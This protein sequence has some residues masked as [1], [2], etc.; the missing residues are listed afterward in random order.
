MEPGQPEDISIGGETGRAVNIVDS[1]GDSG[2][3]GRIVLVQPEADRVF[4]AIGFAP[5]ETWQGSGRANFDAV[6]DS[7]S[8]FPPR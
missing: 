2:V 1:G 3:A 7:V 5:S 4:L 6:V 8:F